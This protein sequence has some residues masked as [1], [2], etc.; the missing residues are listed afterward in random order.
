MHNQ[1]GQ[2]NLTPT[3]LIFYFLKKKKNIIIKKNEV[4]EANTQ[5]KE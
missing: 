1:R 3:P 4:E 5:R 2:V